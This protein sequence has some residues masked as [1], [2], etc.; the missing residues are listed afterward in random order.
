MIGD[1]RKNLLEKKGKE[2]G[3]EEIGGE[4]MGKK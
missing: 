1:E 4:I 2:V 3:L